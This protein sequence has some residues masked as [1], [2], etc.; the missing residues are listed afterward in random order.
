MDIYY[1]PEWTCGR[2]DADHKAAIFYNLIEGMS[3]FF[4]EDSATVVGAILSVRRNE[5]I[6]LE[7]LSQKTG[8][9]PESLEPF[10]QEL[11]RLGLLS[12]CIPG[13]EAIREYRTQVSRFRCLHAQNTVKTTQEKLPMAVSSAEMDYMDK[14]GGITS[15]MFELTYVRTWHPHQGRRKQL[16]HCQDP[17]SVSP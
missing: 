2:Y 15:V 8:I 13:A 3:Y 1:R 5:G 16:L 12:R 7:E 11:T 6:L 14:V 9:L 10:M 4:E 17:A